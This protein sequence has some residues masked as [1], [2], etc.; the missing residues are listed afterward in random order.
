MACHTTNATGDGRPPSAGRQ[1]RCLRHGR[2]LVAWLV[3]GRHHGDRRGIPW[4]AAVAGG[5]RLAPSHCWSL[6]SSPSRCS[7]RA[8]S[9]AGFGPPPRIR[10]GCRSIRTSAPARGGGKGAN[11]MVVV[12][13]KRGR[14]ADRARSPTVWPRWLRSRSATHTTT[15]CRRSTP[16]PL[17]RCRAAPAS[18]L[19]RPSILGTAIRARRSMTFHTCV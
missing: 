5:C 3:G 11:S 18:E 13:A 10:S 2:D 16:Q 4:R 17:P 14:L 1:A 6:R 7:E 9:G 19:C 8:G 15:R 12:A